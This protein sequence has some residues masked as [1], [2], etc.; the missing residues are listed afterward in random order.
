MASEVLISKSALVHNLSAYRRAIGDTWLMAVVKA[1][2]YGHGMIEVA[3]T[4]EKETDWFGVASGA[5]ALALRRAG[6][7]KPILVLSFYSADETAELV[8]KKV[9]LAVYDLAQAKLISQ[10]AKKLKV[11]ANIHLKVDT[12]TSRLGIFPQA[13]GKFVNQLLRLPNLKTEGLFSHFA[14]SEE[15][16]E[17][18][19]QQNFLFDLAID[20]L[21]WRGIDPIQ[22]IA[23]TAAGI[24]APGSR[25]CMVRLGIGLYGLWPSLEAKKQAKF[26]LKPALTWVTRVVQVKTIPKGAF[27][28]YG[29]TF[30]AKRPTTLAVLPIGYFD[31]FDRGLG[32]LGEVLIHGK[33]C[34]VLGRVCMNLTMVDVTD[35]K[36]VKAGDLVVLIGKQGKEEITADELA[37]KL[38]TI[39]YEIVTR[40]NPLI[41]RR[42]I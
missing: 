15:S 18:T 22:H 26:A 6:I 38:G 20:E 5:E 39:N 11:T 21:E 23:C 37:K 42:L 29:L 34:K 31:G 33:R 12:G 9:S 35:V 32:N 8:K 16:L 19:R 36:N 28:G 3:K 14:A 10:A 25:H 4:I 7:K 2:A 30:Q 17:F 24:V 1:N 27:V 40:I 13:V 41:K